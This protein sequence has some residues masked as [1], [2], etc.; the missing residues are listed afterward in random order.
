ML[1]LDNSEEPIL[2]NIHVKFLSNEEFDI[3]LYI[4]KERERIKKENLKNNIENFE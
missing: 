3:D 4:E 1:K 2:A